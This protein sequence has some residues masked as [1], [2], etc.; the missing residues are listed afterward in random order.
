MESLDG[1]RIG[2]KFAAATLAFFVPTILLAQ[3]S[4]IAGPIDGE[5]T[6]ALKGNIHPKAKPQSDQGPVDPATMLDLV[7]LALKP[8]PQQQ[9]A[10]QLLLNEQQDPSSASYHRWLTP[11]QYADSFGL[12]PGDIAKITAWLESQGFTIDHVARS[13]NWVSFSGR[14]E[15]VSNAF[16]TDIHHF[17]VDGELRFA[18][19]TEPSVPAALAPVLLGFLGLDDFRLKSMAREGRRAA[20][21]ASGPSSPHNTLPNGDHVLAPDDIA[22]IY[23]VTRLFQ[24]GV[25]GSGQ[26]IAVVGQSD[27]DLADIQAFQKEFGLPANPPK[28]ILYGTDPGVTG[29]Q[30]EADLDIEWTGAVA[31]ASTIIYVNSTSALVSAAYAI[32]ERLAPVI[33]MS[34]GLC[35]AAQTS[36]SL[37]VTRSWVQQG[38]AEGI[39]WLAASGDSGAAGCDISIST[40]A[41]QGAAVW[42]PAS[43]PE[44]TA[45]GGTEF[46][47]GGN[48]Y[49]SN[50]NAQTGASALSYIP[51][52]AWNESE[53][54]GLSATGGGFSDVY[55]QP[56]W[57]AGPGLQNWGVRAVPDLALAAAND[58]DPYWVYTAGT[59]QEFGGTSVATPVFAG[60]V[61]LL[62]ENLSS[63]GLGNINPTLYRLAQ[64]SVFHD[65]TTG[66]NVVPCKQG[67][68]TCTTGYFGYDAGLGYDPVTG[69]GSVDAYNLVAE[70]NAPTPASNVLPTC[71]PNPVSEQQ[72]NAQGYSWFYTITL[73]ETAGFATSLTGFTFNGT[74]YSSQITSYFGSS[75][76]PA[77][78]N[79]AANLESKGLTVPA[80]VTFSFTGVDAG[81]RQ[82]SKQLSVPFQGLP[83]STPVP[84]LSSV[85]NAASYQA[86]MSPGELATLFGKNLSPVVGVESPGGA[87]SY[88]GVSITVG[89]ILA[90]LFTVA[91]VNGQEQINFQVPSG[92]PASGSAETVQLNNNGSI[93]TI[94]VAT[95]P[96]Q[97]GGFTYLPSASSAPFAVI[98]KPDG[99]V[100]GPSNP[101]ARGSTVVMYMTGLGPTS[102]ALATGQP[103]P[104]PVANTVYEPVVKL[105]GTSVPVL[106]SGAAPGFVGLNQVNFTIPTT[107]QVGPNIALS[108]SI[109]GVTS[110]S[111]EIAV[112]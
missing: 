36:T 38:T 41:T 108:V 60:I 83:S 96:V 48:T 47:E 22:T 16:H 23:D 106:F 54:S 4:Q 52:T 68:P 109:D 80:T 3:Q 76:I 27:I 57:Q 30:D 100:A 112:Q 31:R 103:G 46:N 10:L 5:L 51:E 56:S 64:T 77:L 32:T 102:P 7:T 29:D 26:N 43:V 44:V 13:R 89:G 65:I 92:I 18:N 15:Q 61:A 93:G 101:T 34:F 73:K 97:P 66:S 53:I 35:E 82:W 79:V 2:R 45:V 11:E 8:T 58:H 62:N 72:P 107:A 28:V 88:K 21:G 24:A 37:S 42:S 105:N 17:A 98:V 104:I 12:S 99:S 20:A 50:A 63:N 91:N 69:L 78:G 33:S 19:A 1:Q 40:M 71:T 25:D 49:W 90:P 14:A 6:V 111:S 59:W 87:T 70:W 94:T 75:T 86:G 95:A 81:G 85:V 39:T 55:S 9:A 84:S 110:Q 74:D 67:T